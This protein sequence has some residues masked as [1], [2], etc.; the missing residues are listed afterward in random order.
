MSDRWTDRLS[1]YLDGVLAPGERRDLE[2]H[3]AGCSECTD[4]L[5][6]LRQVVARAQALEDR[7]PAT[8]LWPGIAERIGASSASVSVVELEAHRRRE[9]VRRRRF[10]FSIPQLVAASV[11]LMIV[12]GGTAWL[13]TGPAANRA[14]EATV[15][16]EPGA[17]AVP[18][19]VRFAGSDYDA[20]VYELERI[21]D[22]RRDVLD[23]ETV[24]VLEENLLIIDRAIAQA[25]R[26]LE[27]D[28]ASTY[29]NEH[30]VTTMQQKLELLR[31]AARMAGAAS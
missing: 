26:A 11:A 15:A 28:P 23:E 6:G 1:E 27:L 4:V 21:L 7:P 19:A 9:T 12:S 24:R 13:L 3:L 16:S 25:R 30:L 29:L 2:S 14:G 8:D 5:E 10:S 18:A 31:Q 20:A 17:A 22:E